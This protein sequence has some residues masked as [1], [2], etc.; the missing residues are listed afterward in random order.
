MAAGREHAAG[1]G[2]A[3]V[4]SLLQQQPSAPPSC[5]PKPPPPFWRACRDSRPFLVTCT[6][7]N[8]RRP[9]RPRLRRSHSAPH[10]SRSCTRHISAPAWLAARTSR[11]WGTC[12]RTSRTGDQWLQ[13]WTDRCGSGQ[14]VGVGRMIAVARMLP[15]LFWVEL[16]HPIQQLALQ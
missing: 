13:S 5:Q 3:V 16:P 8:S 11:R 10:R 4:R 14:Q 9:T 7:C 6:P 1:R 12:R 15:L 2:G